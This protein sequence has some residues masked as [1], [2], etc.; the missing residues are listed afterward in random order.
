VAAERIE[1]ATASRLHYRL[2][3]RVMLINGSRTLASTARLR[4]R[5]MGRER[6]MK[7]EGTRKALTEVRRIEASHEG[8]RRRVISKLIGAQWEVED[9]L[10]SSTGSRILSS[11]ER[12]RL[13]GLLEAIDNIVK[14]ME[15]PA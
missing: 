8:C 9:V 6:D 5:E 7:F 11:R 10:F 15:E 1:L 2:S 14:R 3:D 4:A 12:T 13:R